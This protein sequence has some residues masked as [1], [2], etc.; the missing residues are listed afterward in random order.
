MD[1]RAK[2]TVRPLCQVKDR[3]QDS[4]G[5][6]MALTVLSVPYSLNSE[7]VEDLDGVVLGA[8]VSQVDKIF[9]D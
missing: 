3:V 2:P 8:I 9:T 6:N 1:G 7:Q 4:D 5:L